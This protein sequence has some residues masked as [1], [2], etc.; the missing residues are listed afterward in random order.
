MSA[1]R[2]MLRATLDTEKG[3]EAVRSGKLGEIIKETLDHVKP[4][5]AY[6]L[7]E[8]GDR[9]CLLF[10]DMKDSSEL[11][12]VAEPLFTQLDAKVEVIPAMNANDLQKGLAAIG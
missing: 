3:N 10:F 4:E 5:A 8:H 2:V 11:P 6:F 1:M 12:L 7:P 9:A